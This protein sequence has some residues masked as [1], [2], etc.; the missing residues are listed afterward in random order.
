MIAS[1]QSHQQHDWRLFLL[2]MGFPKVLPDLE[3]VT[4]KP[5]R[6]SRPEGIAE[7]WLRVRRPEFYE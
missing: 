7:S 6:N 4:P 2:W 5:K 1:I 3:N